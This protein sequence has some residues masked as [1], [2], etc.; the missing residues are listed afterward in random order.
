MNA[1]DIIKTP[2]I[3]GCVL[4]QYICPAGKSTIGWGTTSLNGKPIP[5]GLT[6]TQQQADTYLANDVSS[7]R[8]YIK[9]LVK[10]PLTT[11]QFEALT[12]FVYNVGYGRFKNSTLLHLLNQGWYQKAADELIRK[13]PDGTLHGWIHGSHNDIEGGLV[14]RRQLEK[15]LFLTP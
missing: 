4:H 5:T 9:Q 7:A 2:G 12:S 13:D 1:V 15:K 6:I 11:N 8:M 14:H 10:V 3:E